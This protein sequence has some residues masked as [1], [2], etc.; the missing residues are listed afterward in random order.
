MLHCTNG[1]E[2]ARN[3]LR[4]RDLPMGFD[5]GY[6]IRLDVPLDSPPK[7]VALPEKAARV[8][9]E[10]AW[11]A[12]ALNSLQV[13]NSLLDIGFIGHLSK[14]ALTAYGGVTPVVFL[15]FSLAMALATGATALVARAFGAGQAEEFRTACKQS[16]AVS[17]ACGLICGVLGIVAIPFATWALLPPHAGDASAF[18]ARYLI[19]Y[20]TG[21]PAIYII[22]ALAG[23]MRGIGDTKSPMVISGIQIL[24][25]ILLNY[26]L[27][28]PPREVAGGIR[29]PGFD[30][31][32][33]GAAMALSISAWMSAIGYLAFVGRTPLGDAWRIQ[34][35]QWNWVVRILRISIPA[36]TMAVLRVASL[37]VFQF[38]LK[39][40]HDGETAIAAIRPGF[41]IESIMFMPSFGLSMAAAALVGQSLGMKRPDRA[42][43]LGWTAAN[44]AALVTLALSIPIFVFAHPISG[45]LIEGKPEVV[46]QTALLLRYLCVTELG[47]AYAMVM[48]GA[49]QGAGD[50]VRPLWITVVCLWGLRVPL[51]WLFVV[52]M[53]MGTAGAWLAMSITQLLQGVLGMAAFKQG[54]WKLKEV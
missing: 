30:L 24:L 50:T 1:Y 51:A 36:A 4:S 22:Q 31:G 17:I 9:W 34:V 12:V 32:L 15:M 40:V 13:I 7:D 6:P 43:V 45:L 5:H 39:G 54:K 46:E 29:L 20:A 11:P 47:F 38:I 26:V 19:V 14:A 2:N 37:G 53:R 18:M 21:L 23:S 49:M 28:F 48:L 35:P 52:P 10:L 25:H 16:V 33:T 41:A 8:V 27:I 3:G 42:E 44:Y